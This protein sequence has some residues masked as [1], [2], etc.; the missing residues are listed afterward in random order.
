MATVI[1]SCKLP[2][3]II[4]EV[5]NVQKKINGYNS[6]DGMIVYE[7]GSAIGIT[8]DIEESFFDSWAEANKGH[9]L[10]SGDA[11][12]IWKT[13][14]ENNAKAQAKE[15]KEVKTGLEQKTKDELE[16]TYG[17]TEKKDTE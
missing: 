2:A 11:P 7:R 4:M 3:G 17:A 10:I 8:Y 15:T 6:E 13:S 1:V 5:N 12:F 14:S 16:K 9:P